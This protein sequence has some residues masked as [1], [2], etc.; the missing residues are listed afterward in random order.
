MP[1]H[2]Y[3]NKKGWNKIH[4]PYYYGGLDN[5]DTY[6]YFSIVRDPLEVRISAWSW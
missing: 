2:L 3:I 6:Q 1:E 4:I 5:S